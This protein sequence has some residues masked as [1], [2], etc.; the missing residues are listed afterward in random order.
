M[1]QSHTAISRDGTSIAY[2]REGSGPPVILVGGAFQF[3]AF[4]PA[5]KQLA[6]LIARRGYTVINY[7]RR[8]RGESAHDGTM[9]LAD[10]IADLWAIVSELE[11]TGD[12]DGGVA[13]FGNSSG[14]A[15][16]LAAAAAGLPVNAL[17][18]FEVPLDS[19][20][21]TDGAEFHAGLRER[22]AGDDPDSVVEYFMKDMPREWL[23]QAKSSPSWPVMVRIGPS[24]EAD[25]ESLA[26]SQSKPRA[27]LFGRIQAPALVLVGEETLDVMAP[28]ADAIVAAMPNAERGT[29][30]AAQHQWQ[31]EDMA[32]VIADFLDAH[33]ER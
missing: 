27:E 29:I 12:A 8:G 7:D 16:A 26:W 13:M 31:P 6:T 21:G 32:N 23:E 28:A 22:I 1:S 9:T 24:L 33:V 3:R 15:I 11:R 5:T 30:P 14:G 10:S 4:D 18:M 19:E 17:V 25:A 20:E 2:D